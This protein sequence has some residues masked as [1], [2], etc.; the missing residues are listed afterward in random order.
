MNNMSDIAIGPAGL[1]DYKVG[2]RATPV[3]LLTFTDKKLAFFLATKLEWQQSTVKVVGCWHNG[4]GCEIKDI[5]S[6]ADII[7][8]YEAI[9]N[10]KTPS[11]YIEMT[12]PM[13]ALLHCRSLMYKHKVQ[14]KK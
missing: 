14:D 1:P 10:Q 7:F 4:I 2:L 13:T 6:E 9:L 8:S 5:G 3:Y 11:Q 12:F